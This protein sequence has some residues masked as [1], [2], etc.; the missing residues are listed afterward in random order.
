MTFSFSLALF[1][2]ARP[3]RRSCSASL[4]PGS[5][6]KARPAESTHSEKLPSANS[7]RASLKAALRFPTSYSSA[8][9]QSNF[10]PYA[11]PVFSLAIAQLFRRARASC[12]SSSLNL[13]LRVKRD[14]VGSVVVALDGSGIVF[15]LKGFSSCFFHL[16]CIC[17]AL[18]IIH[19]SRFGHRFL[20]LAH[21]R[22]SRFHA[23]FAPSFCFV[24][25]PVGHRKTCHIVGL[26]KVGR[27]VVRFVVFLVPA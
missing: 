17:L 19:F 14:V 8:L 11:S 10:A 23:R 16:H 27:Y 20:P 15:C 25:K 13:S 6:S 1:I 26:G 4:F 21:K 24:W 7:D 9:Q 22:W 3:F 5:N 12:C 2:A 18:T